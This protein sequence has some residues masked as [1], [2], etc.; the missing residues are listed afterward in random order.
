MSKKPF[1]TFAVVTLL[2]AG[3]K[4]FDTPTFQ[5]NY[6]LYNREAQKAEKEN[7]WD[8]AAKRYFLALQNAQ[9]AEEGTTVRS[10]FHLKLGRALGATCQFTQSEQNLT[11]AYTLNGRLPQALAE[12]GRLKLA[13]NQLPD[14]LAQFERALPALEKSAA[15]DPIG[16]AEI[17]DDYQAALLKSDRSTDATRIGKQAETLRAANRGQAAATIKPPYGSQCPKK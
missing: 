17:L 5:K 6:S 3:C 7:N 11:Q 10:D 14:A 15:S 4:A 1:L 12:L 9:W 2:L 13:Q 8:A 16:L